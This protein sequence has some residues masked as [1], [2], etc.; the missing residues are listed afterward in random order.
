MKTLLLLLLIFISIPVFSQDD[1]ENQCGSNRWDV[2]TL[3]Y[4]NAGDV[5]LTAVTFTIKKQKEF[6]PQTIEKKHQDLRKKNKFTKL[7]A[8]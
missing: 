1:E 5:R 7:S 6:E 2:K 4:E 3:T 8:T